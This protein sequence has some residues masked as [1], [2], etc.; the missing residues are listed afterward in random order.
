ME[1][2]NKFAIYLRP[3]QML[4]YLK[5]YSNVR[6]EIYLLYLVFFLFAIAGSQSCKGPSSGSNKQSAYSAPAAD[7]NYFQEIGKQIGLD[8]VHSIGEEHINNIVE[9]SGRRSSIPG[10]R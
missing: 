3:D 7:N 4:C 2:L 5:N 10:L 9:S 1:Y 6:R 8:F